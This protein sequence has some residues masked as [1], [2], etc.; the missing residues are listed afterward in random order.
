MGRDSYHRRPGGGVAADFWR[1][2]S[3]NQPD[4]SA[5]T[6]ETIARSGGV[7]SA[8]GVVG[9]TTTG[10]PLVNTFDVAGSMGLKVRI[11]SATTVLTAADSDGV[12]VVTNGAA[13]ITI[14]LPNAAACR[15]TAAGISTGRVLTIKRGDGSTGAI[16]INA[17][18]GNT[19]QSATDTLSTYGA[20]TSL[21]TTNSNSATFIVESATQWGCI[22]NS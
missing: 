14:T 1:D 22:S 11:I 10:T 21:N 5:D 19:V 9:D 15:R 7:M 4:G 3:G 2:A 18:P 20:T 6:T 8:S 17:A 16:T 12:I 13:N